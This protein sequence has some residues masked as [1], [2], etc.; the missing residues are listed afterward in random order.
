[1]RCFALDSSARKRTV[2]VNPIHGRPLFLTD[3]LASVRAQLAGET[4]TSDRL[5]S[6]KLR[7][8]I[9][10]DEIT[11]VPILV[12]F[13]E[14]LG[15]FA[16]MGT[17]IEGELAFPRGAL[18]G[19][20]ISIL[21]AGK[22]YGKGSSRE[23]SPLAEKRA[24]VQL[25]IA[26]S[27]ESIYRQ[28]ADNL[29]LLT[30]TNLA[31]V[32]RILRGEAIPVE[33]ILAERDA[34]TQ[35]IL[36]AGGLLRFPPPR[37]SAAPLKPSAKKPQTLVEKIIT[38]H[39]AFAQRMEAG[40][41]VWLRPDWRFIHDVY[42]AMCASMLDER[43]T[44]AL[45][46]NDVQSI[47]AFEDHYSYTH[48]SPAH[49]AGGLMPELARVAKAH[50]AFTAAHGIKDHGY[51]PGAGGSQGISHALMAERFA[52]PGQLIAGTDSH[53]P[54]SGALGCLAFGVGTT[55]MAYAFVT[56]LARM[57]VPACVRVELRGRLR[58]GVAAKDLVLHL[59]AMPAMRA[60]LG[61]GCVFEFCGDGVAAMNVDER[62]TLTN[63]AAEL[64]GV[65]GI[66][67]PDQ[68]TLRFLKERRGLDFVVDDWMHSDPGATY[69]HE[70]VVTAHD[71]GAMVAAPGDPGR[72][73]AITALVAPV[74]ID[75]AYGGSCTAGKREDFDRYYAVLA[76]AAA[77]GLR[78]PA[79]VQFFLQFG[80]VDV[81]DYCVAQGYLETFAAVG[82]EVLLPACGACANCG[83]GVSTEK[84]QVTISAI[85][86]NF[87][88]RSGPGNVWLGSPET[89][90]ASAIA[91]EIVS[92]EQLKARFDAQN[93]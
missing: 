74:P 62:T 40:T 58:T 29:G 73:R 27:F 49:A 46:L 21:V 84:T 47:L 85:N 82:A 87:P 39:L 19:A 69:A 36:R 18:R 4:L 37:A 6:L 51:L 56:G 45:A 92:F 44:A 91:G 52:L 68:E 2:R 22:R 38:R 24:G 50:R 88:G 41:R 75:I 43:Y 57:R 70:I 12:V 63:M 3:D 65:S 48:R 59:A 8:E 81:Q 71:I 28:N 93:E 26:E 14:R 53:T 64:G 61:L 83:P 31:F 10:T 60:G 30:S 1:M 7:D 25:V 33:E 20:G 80:T 23:H 42:T 32:E 76:W 16:H 5:R 54:H 79:Q 78:A 89:V 34:Q 90:A 9:S 66:V 11:P 15:E 55:D 17:L 72:G 86:R 13:D 77:R 67:A 35:A